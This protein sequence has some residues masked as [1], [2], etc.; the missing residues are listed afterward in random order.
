MCA[1]EWIATQAGPVLV[2]SGPGWDR[3]RYRPVVQIS[4]L[5]PLQVDGDRGTVE[6]SAA[7]ERSLLSTLALH[8]GHMV[9][10]DALITALWGDDPPSAARK[11]R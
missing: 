4:L 5:G 7:K 9:S 8:P 10:T 1:F 11:R 6:L 3:A 2:Q